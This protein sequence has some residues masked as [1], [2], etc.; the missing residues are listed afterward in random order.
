MRLGFMASVHHI[1]LLL[2]LISYLNFYHHFLLS[3]VEDNPVAPH[4][5]IDK[6]SWSV[7]QTTKTY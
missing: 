4:L 1:T 5:G 2:L 3:S 6:R 7:A